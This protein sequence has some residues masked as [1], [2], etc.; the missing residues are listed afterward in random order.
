MYQRFTCVLLIYRCAITLKLPVPD[1]I[2][3]VVTK[4]GVT[5]QDGWWVVGGG[6]AMFEMN[7]M[8]VD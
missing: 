1:I 3:S 4:T 7:S 2:P 5:C 8:T 6:A